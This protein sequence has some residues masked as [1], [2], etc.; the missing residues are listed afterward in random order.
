[1]SVYGD[2]DTVHRNTRKYVAKIWEREAIHSQNDGDV[3]GRKEP[4]ET[5]DTLEQNYLLVPSHVREAYLYHLLCNPPES[6]VHMRRAAGEG[7][8]QKGRVKGRAKRSA[9]DADETPEQPPPTIIFCARARTVAY[10]TSLLQSLS[11]R[12]TGLHSRLTQRERLTSLSLFRA[13]VVPVL[14]STDVGARGLDIEEVAMVVNWDV[15]DQAEEYTHRVGRTARGQRGGVAVSFVTEHDEERVVRIEARIGTKLTEMRM[16]EEK[17]LEK[18][19][20]VSGAKRVARMVGYFLL[21]AVRHAEGPAGT[22]RLW[23][24]EAGSTCNRTPET[25]SAMDHP[26]DSPDWR[27]VLQFVADD[28]A[29]PASHIPTPP[30]SNDGTPVLKDGHPPQ[31]TLVSVST[32]FHPAAQLQ[33]ALPDVVCLSDDAVFFYVHSHRLL[34]ASSNAFHSLLPA[35]PKEPDPVIDVPESSAI[36]NIILHVVYDMSCAHYS[37]SFPQLVSAVKRLSYFGIDPKSVIVPN[38]HIY[39]LILSHAPLYPLELYTLAANYDLYDLAVST[40][41]HLLSFP[42]SSLTDEMA[43]AIGPVYLKRLFFLHFGRSDA[44][45][46]ILLSPPHP[47]PP[48]P[49]CDFADQKKLTRA[50]ALAS[51]YLAWDARPDLSTSTMESAL[52]PLEEHLGCEDCKAALQT[53]IR[54]LVVQWAMVKPTI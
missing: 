9:N 7:V 46:R 36:L 39:T 35:Q 53:R 27:A 33:S 11:I 24:W 16:A 49:S 1:M 18:L 31:P 41:S 19:N 17:V 13:S 8:P 26:V 51:A 12:S 34:H 23:I 42:L 37:P 20:R 6:I 28:D 15:P 21:G 48:T 47:H 25:P 4:V 43:E 54:T 10:L 5:V 45:K 44:L 38:T 2:S 50:W 29:Q 3:S 32:T 14:V 52:R 40:S 22:A 30:L